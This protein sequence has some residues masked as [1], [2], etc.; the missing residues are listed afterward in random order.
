M[1]TRQNEVRAPFDGAVI[2]TIDMA[3]SEQAEQGKA[4]LRVRLNVAEPRAAKASS[5][6]FC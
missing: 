4:E 3:D 1:M 6:A 5:E 2:V